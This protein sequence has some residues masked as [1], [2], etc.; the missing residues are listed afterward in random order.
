M[1]KSEI[2]EALKPSRKLGAKEKAKLDP[3]EMKEF[4]RSR[5]IP[6]WKVAHL[7]K[8]SAPALSGWLKG[9]IPIPPNR[10]DELLELKKEIL[11]WEKKHKRKWNEP[12]P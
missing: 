3:L 5:S 10:E 9:K 4:F 11:A 1:P 2:Y 7:L 12:P 8:V 6:Q